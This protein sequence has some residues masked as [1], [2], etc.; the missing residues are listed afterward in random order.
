MVTAIT[1]LETGKISTKEKINDTGK[2]TYYRD[3]Q[4]YCWNKSGHGYLNV[5][6]AIVHSCNYFFY[7]V[8][9]RVGISDLGKYTRALGLGKKTGV[10]LLRRRSRICG[11]NRNFS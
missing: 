8:G 2:Y 9:R 7:E 5:T 6:D 3:Y 10:E 11:W 4:P 1:G